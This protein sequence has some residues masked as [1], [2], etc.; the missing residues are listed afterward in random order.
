[1]VMIVLIAAIDLV[2]LL[3][4][5]LVARYLS[6]ATVHLLEVLLGIFL[7]AMAVQ[8]MLNGLADVGAITLSGGH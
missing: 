2:V 5:D 1:V 3:G 8:L 6:E 4:S 7:G